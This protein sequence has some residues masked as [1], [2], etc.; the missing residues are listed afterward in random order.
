M[1]VLRGTALLHDMVMGTAAFFLGLVLRLDISGTSEHIGEY[2]VAAALFGVIVGTIG[3]VLGMNRGVWRYAS[4]PDLAAIVK[5]ATA[6]SVVFVAA[7]FF[8]VRLEAIPRSSIVITWAFLI[9][10]LTMPRAAYR[11]YRNGRDRRRRNTS[12]PI[13]TKRALLVGAT[14]NADLFLKLSRERRDVPFEIVAI[15][16]ERGRR[17]GRF[18]HGIPVLGPIEKL[19][20]IMERFELQQRRPEALILTRTREDY[21]RRASLEKLIEAATLNHLEMLRLPN[22]LEMKRF[23]SDIE[24]RPIKLED[25]LQRPPVSLDMSEVKAMIEGKSV[26][27][28]GA[29]GSIGSELVRQVARLS[30]KRMILLDAN[31]YLLYS[32][33]REVASFA[34]AVAFEA[35]LCNVR[36]KATVLRLFEAQRP[37]VIF[38]A[39]ALKHVPVVEAQPLEG[40]FTNAIGTQNVAEAAVHVKAAAMV[41][42]ST[43]KAVNP[44]NVMGASKRMA[45]MFCQAMDVNPGQSTTRFV[46]VRFGNV[47]GSSGSV[48]PLFES[49]IRQGGPVTVTHPDIERYFMTIPEACL[50]L[51]QAAAHSLNR[52]D[53]RGRIFVLDMGEPVKIVDLARNLIRLSGLRPEEDIKIIYRGLRPGE[54]LYEELF[55]SKES[56]KQTGAKGIFMAFPHAV[57][58]QVIA[59]VFDEMRRMIDQ[60]NLA[61][62]L[63]LLKS[64]VTDFSPGAE[65]R[66]MMEKDTGTPSGDAPILQLMPKEPG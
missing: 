42:V 32:I 9:V 62:A 19:P 54:K 14:D 58:R 57:E 30:P 34:S 66:S 43:D 17:T 10:F 47:L 25:L 64:T 1:L 40:I 11:L 52:Q 36:E 50:L 12:R 16:D 13:P 23:D 21:E 46:T 27:I 49:Q 24:I 60:N 41:V 6:S 29:G 48:V 20:Q 28:T 53:E 5:T 61:G 26:L 18:I 59:R 7:H 15:L 37:D 33:E 4:L 63:R 3:F 65:V 31:E 8:L 45:E 56:L 51:M 22:L 39:A 55:Y 2:V 38:H 35:L 44:A